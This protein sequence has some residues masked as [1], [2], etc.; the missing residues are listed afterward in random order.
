MPY[1]TG[2]LLEH[3]DIKFGIGKTTFYKRIGELEQK[4]YDITP[5]K[6]GRTSVYSDRQ[7]DLIEKYLQYIKD[8]NLPKDYPANNLDI[9]PAEDTNSSSLTSESN[10]NGNGLVEQEPI[11]DSIRLD[12]NRIDRESQEEAATREIA[13]YYYR[14]TGNYTLPGLRNQ[15]EEAKE[16]IF[17]ISKERRL[18]PLGLVAELKEK[19]PLHH[20]SQEKLEKPLEEQM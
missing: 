6:E 11:V 13:T 12:Q 19:S 9:V 2:G 4:G 10:G 3:L 7:V 8:G 5:D 1:K 20:N 14:Q 16:Q 18:S 15:V 17:Q